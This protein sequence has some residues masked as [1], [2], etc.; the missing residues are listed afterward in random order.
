MKL[1]AALRALLALFLLCGV[2]FSAQAADAA[3]TNE[4]VTLYVRAQDGVSEQDLVAVLETLDPL[5][6]TVLSDG[7]VEVVLSL[8]GT[9]TAE[10]RERISHL[11]GVM[12]V[13]EMNLAAPVEQTA[14]VTVPGLDESTTQ[15]VSSSTSTKEAEERLSRAGAWWVLGGVGIIC[16]LGGGYILLADARRRYQRR[17]LETAF[18]DEPP[19]A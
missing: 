6:T 4:T 5:Q 9:S 1:R 8:K 15:P 18:E 16:A 7:S 10:L 17:Q 13:G 11:N 3:T 2:A 14:G 19:A 12:Q